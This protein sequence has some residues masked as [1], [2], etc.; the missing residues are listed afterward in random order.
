[1]NDGQSSIEI[2]IG[3]GM[4]KRINDIHFT[5][6]CPYCKGVMDNVVTL[7]GGMI[8]ASRLEYVTRP[9]KWWEPKKWW[10]PLVCFIRLRLKTSRVKELEQQ[11]RELEDAWNER[12]SGD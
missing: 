8:L 7:G 1:M 11:V 6:L 12:Y 3:G 2:K 10:S 9:V 5:V 4:T